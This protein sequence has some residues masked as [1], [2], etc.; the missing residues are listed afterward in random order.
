MYV[1]TSFEPRNVTFYVETLTLSINGDDA[2]SIVA[3]S[4]VLTEFA[5]YVCNIRMDCMIL[6]F[7]I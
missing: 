7:P 4:H 5:Q 1:H 6:K 3:H 2:H